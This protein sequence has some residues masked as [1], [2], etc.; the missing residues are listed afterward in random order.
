MDLGLQGKKAVVLGGTRGIGRSIVETLA[1]EGCTVAL[2]ARNGD[3]V[4]EAVRMLQAGGHQASGAA[5]DVTDG[6]GL[7]AWVE[8][9]GREMGGIDILVS[10]ASALAIGNDAGSW[11]KCFELDVL[12]A[13]Q[14]FEAA[15]PFLQQAA[16][17]KGDAAFTAIGS[18]SGSSASFPNAYGA[19]KS[20]LNHFV[21]G[22]ARQWAPQKVRANVIAPGTVFFEGGVWDMIKQGD[23]RTY[24]T[25]IQ[26]NPTGRMATPQ[27]IADACV[28]LSSPRSTFTTGITMLVDGAILEHVQN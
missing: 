28:F 6:D 8:S 25:T 5:V 13:V 23:P 3:Q 14:A 12:G 27:E 10:N 24:E 2:C 22:V 7:K 20:A 17:Q 19:M 1:A 15:A 16:S 11:R 18:V 26:R 21:K 9:A 4:A